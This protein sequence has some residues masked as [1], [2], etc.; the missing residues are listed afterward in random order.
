MF[1]QRKPF[2]SFTVPGSINFRLLTLGLAFTAWG[3]PE[4][5][6]QTSDNETAPVWINRSVLLETPH[7]NAVQVENRGVIEAATPD[8]VPFYFFNTQYFTNSG[9]IRIYKDFD[10]R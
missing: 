3:V 1:K 8:E 4:P 7:V 10:Y 6:A 5:V 2:D 9:S